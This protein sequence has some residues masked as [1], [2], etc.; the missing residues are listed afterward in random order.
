LDGRSALIPFSKGS[1]EKVGDR[2]RVAAQLID[3]GNGY[4]LWSERFDR[5][6]TDLFAIQDGITLAIVKQLKVELLA[7][8]RSALIEVRHSRG[9][10]AGTPLVSRGTR[11]R[12]RASTSSREI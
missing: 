1:I 3:A 11:T 2:L 10:R 12:S 4:H 8:E 5:Q 9:R 6:M 7:K